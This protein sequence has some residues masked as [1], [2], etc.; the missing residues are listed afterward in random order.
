MNLVNTIVPISIEDLK[1]YFTDKSVYYI[2]NYKDSKLKGAK[3]LTYLSNLDIPCN[4]DLIN[5][6]Q[7]EKYELLD[8]YLKTSMIVNI[9]SLEFLAID[10][11]KEAKGLT[12]EVTHRG[13]IMS[14]KDILETWITKLDS[15]TIFNMSVIGDNQFEEFT[16]QFPVSEDQDLIGVNF[17]SLLKHTEFYDF[18]KKVDTSKLK[19]Y[20]RYFNDYMFKGKSL[21]SFWA[22]ENNPLFLL[23]YGIAEG[24]VD[25]QQYNEAKRQTIEESHVT[26]I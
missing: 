6:E 23:T 17:I 19:F 21:F 26:P 3:L 10:V 14:H 16:K 2:I 9:P 12:A 22:N 13:F 1:K 4:I 8:E 15:L 18:Y 11:L 5:L 7:N 24:L 25:P 20:S